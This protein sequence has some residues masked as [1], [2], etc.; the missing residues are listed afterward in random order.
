[1]ELSE[2]VINEVYLSHIKSL[3]KNKNKGIEVASYIPEN[4]TLYNIMDSWE[5]HAATHIKYEYLSKVPIFTNVAEAVSFFAQY[6]V[7]ESNGLLYNMHSSESVIELE[8]SNEKKY[9]ENNWL[10]IN[11]VI[12]D[13]EHFTNDNYEMAEVYLDNL[14]FDKPNN[15]WVI[16]ELATNAAYNF[17]KD[18]NKL[19]MTENVRNS[20]EESLRKNAVISLTIIDSYLSYN[21]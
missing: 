11:D 21:K 5:K 10:N 13:F 2:E 7:R 1:M 4:T 20:L 12:E 8:E 18:C 9:S 15:S 6:R 19:A 16:D 14:A 17:K 3:K